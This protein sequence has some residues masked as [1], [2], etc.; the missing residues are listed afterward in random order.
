M[1]FFHIVKKKNNILGNG[2]VSDGFNGVFV[3]IIGNGD[4]CI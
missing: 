3:F 4:G 2:K 1:A